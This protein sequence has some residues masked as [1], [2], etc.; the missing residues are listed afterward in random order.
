M[1]NNINYPVFILMLVEP[2]KC[3][4]QIIQIKLI[5]VKN[6]NWPEAP[7]WLFTSMA[8]DLNSVLS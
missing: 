6:P 4:K 1:H 8:E 7:S 5:R 3:L 2:S